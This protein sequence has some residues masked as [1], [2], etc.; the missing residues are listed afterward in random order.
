M[1][2]SW[3]FVDKVFIWLW[4]LLL[5]WDVEDVW[6]GFSFDLCVRFWFVVDEEIIGELLVRFLKKILGWMFIICI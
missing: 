3:V 6:F 2:V 4:K 1:W 5:D